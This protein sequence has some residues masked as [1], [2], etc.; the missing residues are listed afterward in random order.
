VRTFSLNFPGSDLSAAERRAARWNVAVAFIIL[1]GTIG[2]PAMMIPVMLGPIQDDM[3]WSRGAV[4]G[5]NSVKFAVGALTAFFTGH[6]VER[7]GV[8]L[9]GTV[10]TVMA[11]LALV[12]FAY[13]H[14]LAS[15]YLV[16]VLLGISALGTATS[17]KIF[18]SQWFNQGQGIAVGIAFMG[19]SMAGVIVPYLTSLLVEA[20]G[21]RT[22]AMVMSLGIWLVA[23][24]AFVWRATNHVSTEPALSAAPGM[25]TVTPGK[26]AFRAIR[27]SPAMIALLA[28]NFLI[29]MVDESM[30][31]HL[32]LFF[33]REVHLG[34]GIAAI[35]FS[36]VMVMSNVGKLGYGWLIE[37]H[38]NRGAAICWTVA[39]MGVL[40]AL[41]I[42]GM[43]SLVLFAIVYGPTQGGFLINIPVLSKKLFGSVAMIRSIA[44]LT[45]AFNIGAAIGPSLVGYM[46]DVTGS[47]RI[48]FGL[49]SAAALLAAVLMLLARPAAA[50][51][52]AHYA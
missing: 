30:S 40:L 19:L 18:V 43:A 2:I 10:C 20:H 51:T 24:P 47:Y 32:V 29:G 3:G 44:V 12:L 48:P 28:S 6:L 46:Y 1:F 11:G 50:R 8:R 9:V 37:S 7:F 4:S 25:E 5:I 15:F 38:S 34:A 23:L 35:G 22:A 33:D 26:A 17:M 21:W 45:T 31:T 13:V 36:V 52:P 41:P 14:S 39:A 27:F 16:G 42:G 49:L